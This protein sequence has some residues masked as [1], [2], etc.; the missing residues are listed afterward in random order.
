MD[1]LIGLSWRG[2]PAAALLLAGA[3]IS[4]HAIFAARRAPAPGAAHA[5]SG[6][7]WR[8]RRL[9]LGLTLA[10]LGAAWWWHLG[11]LLAFTLVVGG[12]E[13]F[14]SSLVLGALR[15]GAGREAAK[16]RPHATPSR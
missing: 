11:G 6:W 10:G 7:I 2:W 4:L 5:G 15:A 1:T 14:E 12:E 13:L 3:L 16:A 9:M 8:F